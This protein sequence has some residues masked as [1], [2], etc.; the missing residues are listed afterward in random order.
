[1]SILLITGFFELFFRSL[2]HRLTLGHRYLLSTF[3]LIQLLRLTG[4]SLGGYVHSQWSNRWEQIFR[5]IS[6][7]IVAQAQGLQTAYDSVV[8][9]WGQRIRQRRATFRVQLILA[10]TIVLM[11]CL[12][13]PR[14]VAAPVS[15]QILAPVPVPVPAPTMASILPRSATPLQAPMATARSTRVLESI[16]AAHAQIQKYPTIELVPIA[17][18]IAQNAEDV[19]LGEEPEPST[20]RSPRIGVSTPSEMM[21]RPDPMYSYFPNSVWLYDLES[22]MLIE[23]Y[24]DALNPTIRAEFVSRPPMTDLSAMQPSVLRTP[25][26]YLDVFPQFVSRPPMGGLSALR[27][28][29]DKARASLSFEVDTGL[30]TGLAPRGLNGAGSLWPTFVPPHPVSGAHYWLDPPFSGGYNQLYSPSYQFGST[31]GGHYRIHHGID[32]SNPVGTPVLATA[33]GKVIHAGPDDPVLL[34][35]YNNFY[36]NSVV[37]RLD[38]PL[39]TS[40]G[41]LNVYVLYGHLASVKVQQDQWVGAGDFL[42]GV[43]MTGIAIGPHLHLEVRVGQNSYLHTVNPALWVRPP[44]HTG[45]VAVRLLS[46]NSR[47]WSGIPLTLFRYEKGGVR[48]FRVFETYPEQESIGPDPAWGENGALGNIPAG[49]YYI[50]AHINGEEISQN[51]T[52]R[53]GATTF[54]ELRTRQ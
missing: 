26:P 42:G 30:D 18:M 38:R 23:S 53:A 52:V 43:G 39:N 51:I 36:G 37:I 45:T 9:I 49:A 20:R 4:S 16:P 34:G 32:I 1:M 41:E 31:G 13:L 47:T 48:W 8:A 11:G 15:S 5:R 44:P 33:S 46:A 29:I 17:P 19:Q 6:S 28:E 2:L 35:P 10:L 21:A 25:I 40:Q 22:M 27:A 54:V 24:T 3:G 14:P 50:E 7:F 12:Y